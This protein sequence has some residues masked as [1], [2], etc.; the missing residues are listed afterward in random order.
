MDTARQCVGMNEEF[1][2]WCSTGADLEGPCTA[3]AELPWGLKSGMIAKFMDITG[4]TA[5]VSENHLSATSWSMEA[6]VR[7]CAGCDQEDMRI[8]AGTKGTF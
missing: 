4:A 1:L 6:A 2:Q 3:P 7:S 5:A 8:F